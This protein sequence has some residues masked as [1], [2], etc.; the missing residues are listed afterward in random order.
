MKI[1]DSYELAVKEFHNERDCLHLLRPLYG[2]NKHH[3]NGTM[4]LTM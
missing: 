1:P 2:L 4:N 3:K